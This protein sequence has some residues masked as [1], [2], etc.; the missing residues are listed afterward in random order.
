[1]LK[2]GQ[3]LE[4]RSSWHNNLLFIIS[5]RPPINWLLLCVVSV[6]GFIAISRSYYSGEFDSTYA[7]AAR[8][9]IYSSYRRLKEQAV[10]DYLELRNLGATL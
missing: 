6:F 3:K 4:T 8:P 5:Q 1:M 2:I 10:N 7:S 9:N